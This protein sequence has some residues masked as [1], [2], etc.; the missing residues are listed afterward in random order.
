MPIFYT[1]AFVTL[2]LYTETD[3]GLSQYKDV[4]L[5]V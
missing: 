3:R 1:V 5:P 4:V 2:H